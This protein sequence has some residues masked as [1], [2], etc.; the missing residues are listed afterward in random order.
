MLL[1]GPEA[2]QLAIYI[3]WLLNGIGGGLI[4]GTLFVL[5]G[6]VAL[7]ALSAIYV[8]YGDTAAIDALFL[9]LAPAVIAI[10]VQQVVRVSGRALTAPVLV[11]LAVAAFVG[12]VFLHSAA[13]TILVL[14]IRVPPSCDGLGR[15]VDARPA[16]TVGSRLI[17]CRSRVSRR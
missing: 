17:T 13:M 16:G 15:T 6:A 10:V 14:P 5:P 1:P 7:L 2:Q 3:G 8:G 11:A 9:G 12:R 4:A